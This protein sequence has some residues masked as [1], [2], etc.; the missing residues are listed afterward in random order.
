MATTQDDI[1]KKL[2]ENAQILKDN[3]QKR[4]EQ[5]QANM[6]ANNQGILNPNEETEQNT[7]N[8]DIKKDPNKNLDLNQICEDWLKKYKKKKP[9][10][11]E[12]ENK[13]KVDQD[14]G[15]IV[16]DF[17]DTKAEEDFLRDIAKQGSEGQVTFGGNI[18]ALT[19]DGELIDPRTNKAFPEGGYK[20]LV[21]QL[22]AGKDYNDIPKPKPSESSPQFVENQS[23]PADKSPEIPMGTPKSTSSFDNIKNNIND[24]SSKQEEIGLGSPAENKVQTESLEVEE[25]ASPRI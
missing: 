24:V 20:D 12:N 8:I 21:D 14:N 1:Q 17:K 11:D 4:M 23:M 3:N 13:L 7:K 22:R 10:F 15:R 18:I 2:N 9:D 19:K 5:D 25:A 16:M 6:A